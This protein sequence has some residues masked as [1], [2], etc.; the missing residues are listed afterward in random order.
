[1][2]GRYLS[3]RGLEARI[4][5]AYEV[6]GHRMEPAQWETILG[7][8]FPEAYEGPTMVFPEPSR[9]PKP[10]Q[11]APKLHGA[12]GVSLTEF[13]MEDEGESGENL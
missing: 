6:V 12:F 13:E 10:K 3:H 8:I 9:K 5:R 7:E 1:M 4:E 2:E 11:T